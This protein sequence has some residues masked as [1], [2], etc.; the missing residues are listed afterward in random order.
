MTADQI[1]EGVKDSASAT[2]AKTVVSTSSGKTGE[3]PA[4]EKQLSY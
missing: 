2:A 1:W 4:K 3:Q